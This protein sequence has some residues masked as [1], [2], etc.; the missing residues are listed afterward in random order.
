MLWRVLHLQSRH[1]SMYR[2]GRKMPCHQY[3]RYQVPLDLPTVRG[4]PLA[5]PLSPNGFI[6]LKE[7]WK[8]ET[9]RSPL[10]GLNISLPAHV[11]INFPPSPLFFPTW[12]PSVFIAR[13]NNAGQI[14]FVAQRG[15]VLKVTKNIQWSR[16]KIRTFSY[17]CLAWEMHTSL[18]SA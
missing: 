10:S 8:H 3:G 12:S 16:F 17:T 9:N 7:A 13:I 1:L 11:C 4:E 2:Y 14:F 6:G 15:L 18:R 5:P